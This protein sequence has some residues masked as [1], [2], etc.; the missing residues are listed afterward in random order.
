MTID[1]QT[2]AAG[3]SAVAAIAAAVAA[4]RGPLSAAELAERLRRAGEVEHERRR[5]K[6]WVFSTLLQER[7]QSYSIEGVRAF[8]LI[9]VVFMDV[10]T[11]REAWADLYTSY[12]AK[13]NV[14]LHARD[15]RMRKLLQAMAADL[16]MSDGLRIDDFT[17]VYLPNALAE[18]Q[19][20]QQLEREAALKR[21]QV[22]AA[23]DANVA[24]PQTTNWPPKPPPP[25]PSS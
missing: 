6:L 11:V 3:L 14:P 23:P 7:A 20:L 25:A 2:V 15:E 4:W 18:E 21:L 8:N 12:D 5:L 13:N 17:R 10:K 24:A 1:W 19:R 9:D 22:G 16:Q